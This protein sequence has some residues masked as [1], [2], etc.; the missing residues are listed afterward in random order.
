MISR[1]IFRHWKKALPRLPLVERDDYI[2]ARCANH[3]V[4]HLGA[5]DAPYTEEHAARGVLLHQK[6][7]GRCANLIGCD[8][9]AQ[10][11]ELLRTRFGIDDIV[12]CDLSA[13]SV[14]ASVTGDLI[15]C[16]DMIEHVNNPGVLLTS[17]NRMLPQGGDLLVSTIH[18]L[19][20]KY[21]LRA[22]FTGAETVHPDHVTYFSY[23][24]LGVLLDRFGFEV[25]TARYY[26]YASGGRFGDL[27][28]NLFRLFPQGAD[29]IVV[30]ARKVRPV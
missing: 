1:D 10:A 29:G 15:V 26:T 24:T 4:I 25:K 30:E 9:N 22:F 20:L 2:L 7:R 23:A 19:S 17:C 12:V 18:A 28:N 13:D 5:C 11:A 3:R 27:F 16:A 8:I 6:L 21:A 14:P